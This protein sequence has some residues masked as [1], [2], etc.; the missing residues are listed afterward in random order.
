[1]SHPTSP[2]PVRPKIAVVF[3]GRSSEH[4]VSCL[5]AREVLAVID[6]DRYDVQ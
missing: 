3:G 5:T 1:M 2:A 4:G 6:T